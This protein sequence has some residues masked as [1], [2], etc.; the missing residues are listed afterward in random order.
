MVLL[1]HCELARFCLLQLVVGSLCRH[2]PAPPH[3]CD[4]GYAGLVECAEILA[5]V[6]GNCVV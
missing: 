1:V 3:M 2:P 5:V 6:S 4:F